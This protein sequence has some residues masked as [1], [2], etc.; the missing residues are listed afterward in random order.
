MRDKDL[1]VLES[2]DHFYLVHFKSK[3]VPY[4]IFTTKRKLEEWLSL[5][6]AWIEKSTVFQVPVDI[7]ED[8]ESMLGK[9]KDDE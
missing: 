5:N 9:G 4:R 6:Y 8:Q 7:S 2:K 1:V 3:G